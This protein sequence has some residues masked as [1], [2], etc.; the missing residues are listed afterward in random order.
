MNIK[1]SKGKTM[2]Y[3]VLLVLSIIFLFLS[4][5]YF[6]RKIDTLTAIT[7]TFSDFVNTNELQITT[8][9]G[10][11]LTLNVA[12][13]DREAAWKIYTHITTRIATVEFNEEYDSLTIS[14]NSLHKVFDLIRSEI[15]TIPIKRV[16]ND[17]SDTMVKFYVSILNDGIRPYL[18]KWHIPLRTWIENEKIK[19]PSKSIIEIERAY[20]KYDE[21]VKDF[22]RMNENMQ[23]FSQQLLDI[24]KT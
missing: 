9:I 1:K 19:D 11:Q 24:V 2:F 22:K 15:S 16:R 21:A 12:Q 10:A 7:D 14:H 17:K 4:L 5:N 23:R 20:P 6:G 3:L 13:N 18:S 8:P